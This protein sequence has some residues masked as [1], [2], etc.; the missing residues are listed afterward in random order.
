MTPASAILQT[1]DHLFRH[2][3]GKMVSVLTKL[4]GLEHLSKAE[5]L[6]QDTLL[7]AMTSWSYGKMPENP[8]AWLYRVA[9]NKAID[10][11]RREK[12]YREILPQYGYLLDN[13]P[14][15]EMALPQLFAEEEIQDSQLKMIFACCHPSIPLE[16]QIAFAL[17]TLCG[18]GSAEIARAFLTNEETVAKRIYRAKEKVRMEKIELELPAHT[19]LPLRLGAVLHCLYL[20]FNEGY[21]S[22]HPDHLIREELCEEAMRLCYLLTQSPITDT[23]DTR[24]LLSLFC[25]QSSRLRARLDDRGNILLLKDQDRTQ[26]Y[27]PLLQRGF[28]FLDQSIEKGEEATLYQLEAAIAAL[29]ASAASFEQTDWKSI[30]AL[31]QK[32]YQ[33]QPNPVIALN[34]AIAAA[35]AISH[36]TALAQL[37]EIEGLE[38]YYLYPIALGEMYFEL[39]KK[40]EAK[41]WYEKGLALSPS[42]MEQKLVQ[43]KIA[44]CL[45]TQ[46]SQHAKN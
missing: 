24:A 15:W 36:E 23:A 9:K 18:L 6:V 14:A 27:Q 25:F 7:Q 30:Y 40:E 13:G 35:F 46:T 5:D 22:S 1:V 20:L 10:F 4:L 45:P 37:Q 26:W 11:L 34:K 29:H 21:N 44:N 39:R 19:A 31:Y 33:L 17:K 12:R 3:S 41:K 28:L 32:R 2:E 38:N 16:S 43:S 42:P 8:Q